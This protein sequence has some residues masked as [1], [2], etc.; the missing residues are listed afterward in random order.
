MFTQEKFT[1]AHREV[2]EAIVNDYFNQ[3]AAEIAKN[4]GWDID[5]A[6]KI[7]T[8]GPY[9]PQRAL[10]MK[11]IDKIS[12]PEELYEN[13]ETLFGTKKTNLLYADKYAKK[14]AHLRPYSSVS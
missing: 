6:K 9:F 5:A 14:T 11:L 2:T 1:E 4:R 10:D 3:I 12:Y 13:L 7:L 8:E